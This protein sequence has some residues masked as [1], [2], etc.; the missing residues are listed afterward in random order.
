MSFLLPALPPQ[1]AGH[2]L[3]LHPEVSALVHREVE[4]E[5][6]AREGEEGPVEVSL[7]LQGENINRWLEARANVG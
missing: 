6:V 7:N 1:L 3:P 2:A 5:V 4:L